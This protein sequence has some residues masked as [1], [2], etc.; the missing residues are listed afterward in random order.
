MQLRHRF[1]A[2]SLGELMAA[3]HRSQAALANAIRSAISPDILGAV[4][5][6]RAV[7]VPRPSG[8]QD[9]T[10]NFSSLASENEFGSGPGAPRAIAF[11]TDNAEPI[12]LDGELLRKTYGLTPA[13]VRLTELM[14]E[15]LTIEEAAERLGVSRH[16]AKTQLQSIYM[17]TNANNRAKLMRLIM[18]LSQVAI[19]E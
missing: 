6:S 8:R 12:R 11:I 13:E 15:S 9:Y 10:L 1:G 7:S 5:F 2:S 18:S 19:R 4:H 17:K 14:A 16:T 3:D